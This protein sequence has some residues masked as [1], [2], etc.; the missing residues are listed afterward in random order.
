MYINIDNLL[1]EKGKTRYWLSK[2]I[3]LSYPNL[4]KL[5]DNE[6]SSIKFEIIENICIALNC[7]PN[8]IFIFE[9]LTHD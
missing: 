7:S 3:N 1:K 8:D 5:A 6:T 2:K 4:K 9:P